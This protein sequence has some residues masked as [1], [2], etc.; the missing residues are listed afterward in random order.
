MFSGLFI[1]SEKRGG[2]EDAYPFRAACSQS[3]LKIG[4][5]WSPG[6]PHAPG[7]RETRGLPA[8]PRLR[9]R[10]SGREARSA[11]PRPRKTEMDSSFGFFRLCGLEKK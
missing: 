6:R 1:I 10:P 8:L 2:D 4:F 5:L 11:S 7:P 9:P 3:A